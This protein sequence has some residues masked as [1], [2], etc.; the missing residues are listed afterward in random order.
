M[1]RLL[2]EIAYRGTNYHG[3]QVQPNA[4]TVAETLQD[5]IEAV[6]RKREGIVGCSRTD[7]GV[8]ANQFYFHM[9]TE[10]T[11]PT[12]AAVIALNN[13]L[14]RDIAVLSCRQVPE[15]FHARY[16]VER[17]EYVYKIWDA[18]VRNPILDGLVLH[19]R[20][21]L[22]EKE[23]DVLAHEFCG[24]HDF[25]GFCSAGGKIHDTVRTIFDCGVTRSGDLVEFRVMGDGF[26]YNMVRI[27]VGTLLPLNRS[28][29]KPGDIT[30]IVE[31]KERS[32]AGIT[33]PPDG[34]YLNRVLYGDRL[35]A[36]GGICEKERASAQNL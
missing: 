34:L 31:S 3:Y 22:E 5:A 17:K 36:L 11:I 27:M 21:R 13:H 19:S 6:F 14:P 20:Y 25:I 18:P 4:P 29:L 33:V 30:R 32:R 23:L 12:E 10:T 8:H 2:F 1:R 16:S 15:N 9:N 7:T 28:R 24:T 35:E 26:L